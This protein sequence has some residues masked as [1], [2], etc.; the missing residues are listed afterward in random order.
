MVCIMNSVA[1]QLGLPIVIAAVSAAAS[2]KNYGIKNDNGET[3]A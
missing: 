1:V 2:H 3:I